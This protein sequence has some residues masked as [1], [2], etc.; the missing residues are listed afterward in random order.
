[1]VT[2]GARCEDVVGVEA[3]R[4]DDL[5]ADARIVGQR[6]AEDGLRPLG[7]AALIED[8]SDRLGAE[9]A[10]R[11]RVAKGGIERVRAVGVEKSEQS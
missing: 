1:M 5:I 2:S 11:M 4:L 6:G 8:V 9:G 10:S 3:M 7:A